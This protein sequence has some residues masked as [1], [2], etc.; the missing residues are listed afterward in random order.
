MHCTAVMSF[1]TCQIYFSV[2]SQYFCCGDAGR[3]RASLFSATLVA[4]DLV[5]TK[6]PRKLRGSIATAM[7]DAE[8]GAMAGKDNDEDKFGAFQE[9]TEDEEEDADEKKT[10]EKPFGEQAD[11]A[12]GDTEKPLE[13]RPNQKL[14]P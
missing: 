9:A 2:V 13:E 10:A 11:A 12:K 6:A 7:E 4:R 5:I 8:E 14:K 3:E 1:A